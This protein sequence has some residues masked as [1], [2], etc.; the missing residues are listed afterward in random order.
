MSGTDTAYGA[1]SAGVPVCQPAGVPPFTVA[2][3]LFMEAMIIMMYRGGDTR[4]LIGSS[5]YVDHI[6][7]RNTAI[8]CEGVLPNMVAKLLF[9]EA[10]LLFMEAK[11]LF[12]E[13][14]LLFM[15]A[16]L[17]FMEAK[18][19]FMEAMLPYMEAALTYKG[20]EHQGVPRLPAAALPWSALDPRP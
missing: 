12:M 16:K 9:R 6:Y 15:E 18:L 10:R 1:T 19:L 3:L 5:E 2:V 17:L 11:L 20:A 8:N 7:G 14:K 4:A 13:A